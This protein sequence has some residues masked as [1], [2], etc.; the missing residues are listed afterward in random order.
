MTTSPKSFSREIEF[1]AYRLL[2]T[3]GLTALEAK[4][5]TTIASDLINRWAR[6]GMVRVTYPG[7]SLTVHTFKKYAQT[8][9]ERRARCQRD[10]ALAQWQA[11]AA[12]N[13]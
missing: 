10:G 2:H 7:G 9:E 1:E 11:V 13:Y 5:G 6:A 8:D 12:G 4:H 3:D